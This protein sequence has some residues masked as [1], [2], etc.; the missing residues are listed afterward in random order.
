MFH[1]FLGFPGQ[2]PEAAQAYE[3]AGAALRSALG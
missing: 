3:D 2:L 1:G